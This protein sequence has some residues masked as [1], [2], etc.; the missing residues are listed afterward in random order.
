MNVKDLALYNLIPNNKEAFASEVIR[1][2]S[3]LGANPNDLMKVMYFESKLNPA[4]K[5]PY[6]SATGLLQ[7]TSATAT[8]LGTSTFALRDMSNVDQL[9]YVYL[10]LK[11]YA[12]RL[13]SLTDM[14][15]AVF[16]PAALSKPSD[17]VLP[18]NSTWVNA[19]KIFDVNGDKKIQKSEITG[20]INNY[21]EKLQKKLGYAILP[22]SETLGA[23]LVGLT[24]FF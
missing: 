24:F 3:L 23:V 2:S 19:N 13:N 4:A 12:K 10:Y 1:I 11:P 16:Y 5:N 21:F 6:G 22:A 9:R 14:Y 8:G 15:L 7:F 17:Y 20:Y 18:L